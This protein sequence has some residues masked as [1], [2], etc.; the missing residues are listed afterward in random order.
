MPDLSGHSAA[1]VELSVQNKAAAKAGSQ[2]DHHKILPP[3]ACA[4][5]P[6]PCRRAVGIVFQIHRAVEK[7]AEQ[8]LKRHVP[9]R[10]IAGIEDVPLRYRTGNPN[11]YR[12]NLVF[13]RPGIFHCLL[14]QLCQ[15]PDQLLRAFQRP[16]RLGHAG[17]QLPLLIHNASPQVGSAYVNPDIHHACPPG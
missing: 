13:R 5:E 12:L 14:S 11:T 6:L 8:L 3:S 7:A 17:E 2:R 15:T 16:H 1:A 4:V 9:Q 10:E